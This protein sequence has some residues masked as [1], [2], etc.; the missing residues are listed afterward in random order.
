MRWSGQASQHE[1]DHGKTNEGGNGRG[2]TLEVSCQ[3]AVAADPGKRAFHHPPFGQDD[4]AFGDVA[5][6]DDLDLPCS[7]FCSSGAHTR[8]LIAT[9][10]ED[11]FDEREQGPRLFGQHL[12]GAVAI[13]NIGGVNRHAQQEAERIDEDVALAAFDFLARIEAL[14]IEKSPPLGAPLVL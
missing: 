8:P 13:L 10:G 1:F 5:A 4:E 7:A 6:F 14:G 9:I 12:R 3:A 11:A 2:V